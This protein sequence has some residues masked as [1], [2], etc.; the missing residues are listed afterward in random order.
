MAVDGIVEYAVGATYF[1]LFRTHLKMRKQLM[2]EQCRILVVVEYSGAELCPR[3]R[4]LICSPEVIIELP[5]A[6]ESIRHGYSY[7]VLSSISCRI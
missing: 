5:A 2:R 3:D 4:G 1:L 7:R 6:A